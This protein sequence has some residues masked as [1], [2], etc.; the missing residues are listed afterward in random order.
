M[1]RVISIVF[2]VLLLSSCSYLETLQRVNEHNENLNSDKKYDEKC[3][4]SEACIVLYGEVDVSLLK[5]YEYFTIAVV[6][7]DGNERVIDFE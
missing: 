3:L 7:E 2:L 1:N 6:L 4:I 5:E